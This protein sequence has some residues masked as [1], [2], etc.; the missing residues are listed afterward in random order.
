M[1]AGKKY[2]WTISVV[3]VTHTHGLVQLK[4]LGNAMVYQL[5]NTDG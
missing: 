4:K 3:A 1:Q 2:F 5:H